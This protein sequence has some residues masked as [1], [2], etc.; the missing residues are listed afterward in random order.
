MRIAAVVVAVSLAVL[1]LAQTP[2]A[3]A[4]EPRFVTIGTGGVT[5][6]YYPAGGAICRLV[7]KNRLAHGVRCSPE[8][9]DGSVFN[10]NAIRGGE[11]D[12]GI[13]QSDVQAAALAG[14][15]D[16]KGAGP[17]PN[18]RAVFSLHAEPLHL[19]ARADAGIQRF[20]DLKGKRV[21]IG[22]PGSGQ[23]ATTELILEMRGWTPASFSLAAEIK[24]SDQSAALCGNKVDAVLFTVGIP[25]AAI[26]EVTATCDVVLVPIEGKWADRLVA[27]NPAYAKAVIPGGVYRNNEKDVPTLGP[28]ATL[29]TSA[30]LSDSVVYDVVRAVFE[31]FEDLRRLHPALENLNKEEMAKAGLSAPLH[32]G[33]ARYFREAG[34]IR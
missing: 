31:G 27:E 7:N 23:R 17:D 32:P 29:V 21:N 28:R 4:A 16:F 20:E 18:L 15:L 5:G 13:V 19:V 12:F 3:E 33:A 2:R 14:R 9:T 34:L 10:I 24:S 30:S 1:S 8:S 26:K 22:N 6:V 25:S 11:L